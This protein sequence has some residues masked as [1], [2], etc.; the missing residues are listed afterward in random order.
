MSLRHPQNLGSR[1]QLLPCRTLRFVI[2]RIKPPAHLESAL[3]NI[4]AASS[5]YTSIFV[6]RFFC[7]KRSLPKLSIV[8][9]NVLIGQVVLTLWP[10]KKCPDLC[11]APCTLT[12]LNPKFQSKYIKTV[13]SL[14]CL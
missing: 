7:A 8:G 11:A 9:S 3:L 14:F 5:V 10:F 4:C 2:L 1:F 6:Q 12:L 13:I